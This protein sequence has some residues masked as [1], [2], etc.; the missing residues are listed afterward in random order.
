MPTDPPA[1]F[2]PAELALAMIEAAA[3]QDFDAL[4]RLGDLARS[5]PPADDD[6]GGP[7]G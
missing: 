4:G 1:D 7:G 3:A 6:G 5:L 2:D